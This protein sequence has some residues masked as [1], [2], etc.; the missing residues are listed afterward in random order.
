MNGCVHTV[1]AHTSIVGGLV[2]LACTVRCSRDQTSASN[3]LTDDMPP[4]AC[5]QLSPNLSLLSHVEKCRSTSNGSLVR[6][7]DL[8]VCAVRLVVSPLDVL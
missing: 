3:A 7:R 8:H 1:D 4:A 6:S 2:R 5:C